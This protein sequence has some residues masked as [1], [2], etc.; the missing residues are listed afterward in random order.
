MELPNLISANSQSWKAINE[1]RE[2]AIGTAH[3]K[4]IREKM[5]HYKNKEALKLTWTFYKE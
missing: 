3:R 4:L 5:E 1:Q 2:Y